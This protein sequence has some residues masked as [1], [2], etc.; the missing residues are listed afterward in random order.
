MTLIDELKAYRA[1][2]TDVEAVIAQERLTASI[3]ARRRQGNAAY[4]ISDGLGLRR[5]DPNEAGVHERWAKLKEKAAS[6]IPKA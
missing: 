4:A 3:G 2:G 6:H 1:R 5:E